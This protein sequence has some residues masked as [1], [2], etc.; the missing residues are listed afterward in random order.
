VGSSPAGGERQPAD[1][2][3]R[4][5]P[6]A[7]R[8]SFLFHA[9]RLELLPPGLARLV[10]QTVERDSEA[11]L[12]RTL[13]SL[14]AA[15]LESRSCL[16]LD[17]MCWPAIPDG[18]LSPIVRNALSS[19]L[20]DATPRARAEALGRFCESLLHDRRA[21]GSYFTPAWIADEIARTAI[22]GLIAGRRVSPD[23]AL[24]FRILDPAVGAG[25]FAIAAIEAVAEAIGEEGHAGA[26]RSA[27]TRCIFC[28]DVSPLAADASRLAVWLFASRPGSPATIPADHVTVAE[29][30]SH[31]P[32]ARSFDAVIGNPP[33]G[34]SIPPSSSSPA[35]LS[36]AA[37]GGQR[38]SYLLFLLLAAEAA[39]DDGV[40]A[41]LVPDTI[42]YQVRC[43]PMRRFLLE[44][45]RPLR[46]SLLGDSIFP[47]ATAP[48]AVVCLAGTHIAPAKH[49]SIDLRCAPRDALREMISRPGTLV[50]THAPMAAPHASFIHPPAWLKHLRDRL[51]AALPLLGDPSLGIR[52]HD[53]GINY[54]NARAGR[55][56]LYSGPREH[57]DDIPV[58]RGRDF[59]P[60][61]DIGH[62]AWLRRDWSA[63]V[64]RGDGVSVR[65]DF[66]RVTP[67]LLFRQTADR[68]V[69]TI[70]RRG[71]H[72]GRSVIAL[73]AAGERDLLALCAL[74]N[75]RA[76][77]A[78]YRAVAPEHGRA[79]AQVKVSKLRLLPIPSLNNEELS[80]LAAALLAETDAESRRVLVRQ[81]DAA[82]Y[83]AY[84]LEE[85]EIANIEQVAE[86]CLTNAARARRSPRAATS[87]A[88]R[89]R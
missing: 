19:C 84:D 16:A 72:F 12:R 53:V 81:M 42:L 32:P 17:G 33:W 69:A 18:P 54:G 3:Q 51:A 1:R 62:S 55:A 77:A 4:D 70:D 52:F 88:T 61:T 10:S 30:L 6:L 45:F 66:Y 14:R 56:I 57:P 36:A 59:G 9:L 80:R 74:M 49:P 20:G 63:L 58:T 39:R 37:L 87:S 46:I 40:I 78:L 28:T 50:P 68:P 35:L 5:A 21:S 26:I 27:A 76:F 86:P 60:F 7:L 24:S 29:A 2:S 23:R 47:G 25:A 65:D 38:D 34:A 8:L 89:T 75:S 79:F 67:K 43:E 73:T 48:A 82:V 15:F 64:G 11:A 83:A 85:N 31:P 22:R 41:M 13:V 71:V 44:R